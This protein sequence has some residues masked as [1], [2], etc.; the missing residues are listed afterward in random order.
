[1]K[2]NVV[3]F[4]HSPIKYKKYTFYIYPNTIILDNFPH[5]LE[6]EEHCGINSE[7]GRISLK[8]HF[9]IRNGEVLET[10]IISETRY[11]IQITSDI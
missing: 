5:Y 9:G 10:S 11:F 7:I 4:M 2:L 1:M 8:S 3:Y 6:L